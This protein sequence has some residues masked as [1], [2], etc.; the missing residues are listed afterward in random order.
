MKQGDKRQ[1]DGTT[2]RQRLAGRAPR[3]SPRRGLSKPV[4]KRSVR[5]TQAGNITGYISS[6]TGRVTKQFEYD[7][8]GNITYQNGGINIFRYR[9]STKFQDTETGLYYYGLRYYDPVWGRW[10]NRDP[11]EEAG[12]LNLYAFCGNDGVNRMDGLGQRWLKHSYC[13]YDKTN[14]SKRDI[15]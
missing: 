2:G 5:K 13:S 6:S 1:V 8:Y 12:G 4:D 9:F 10:I 15:R 7:A 14:R 11:I 3:L